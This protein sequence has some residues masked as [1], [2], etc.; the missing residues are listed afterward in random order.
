MVNQHGHF[1]QAEAQVPIVTDSTLW[2]E[3]DS[4]LG[5]L[6]TD[7]GGNIAVTLLV[8]QHKQE[9]LWNRLEGEENPLPDASK[10]TITVILENDLRDLQTYIA[11]N[12]FV[13]GLAIVEPERF[14]LKRR[15]TADIVLSNVATSRLATHG[16]VHAVILETVPE[17]GSGLDGET[18]L[19]SA[20]M[21]AATV[22]A[23]EVLPDPRPP[24]ETATALAAREAGVPEAYY[25]RM[26]GQVSTIAARSYPRRSLDL[27]EEGIV[28]MLIRVR[29]DGS[30]IDITIEE[31]RTSAPPRLQRAA[32][33]AVLRVAPFE[34]LPPGA[35]VKS[36]L[37]PVVYRLAESQD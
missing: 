25:V 7:H 35:G 17:S 30:V 28:V 23:A 8:D 34:P 13:E 32:Q 37:I 24:L 6:V 5:V 12:V 14:E 36:I 15:Q 4:M 20:A 29:E 27:G 33:R 16:A 18:S 22:P 26:R 2:R 9:V 10:V 21:V 19:P 31:G 1:I 3:M 11:E